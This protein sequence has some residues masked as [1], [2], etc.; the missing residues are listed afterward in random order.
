VTGCAL[1]S[2]AAGKSANATT[3]GGTKSNHDLRN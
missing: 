3:V 2:A 1:T